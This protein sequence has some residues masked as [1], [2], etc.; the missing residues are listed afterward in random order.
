M[1][2]FAMAAASAFAQEFRPQIPKAWD[3]EQLHSMQL[4]LVGIGVPPKEAP[5]EYYYR[6]PAAT[7]YRSYP[8]YLPGKEPPG[9]NEWL[10]QQE[11]EVVFDAAKLKSEADWIRVGEAIFTMPALIRG[12]ALPLPADAAFYTRNG[13]PVAPNGE[14]PFFR[15]VV[16][17]K[18]EPL[19]S[20][21]R[22]ST[23]HVRVLPDGSIVMGAQG[24]SPFV[25]S[26]RPLRRAISPP[27][28][29]P[30]ARQLF[31]RW[32]SVQWLKPDPAASILATTAE[33]FADA[34]ETE[35]AG[36]VARPGTSLFAPPKTPDLIGIQDRKYLDATG[37]TRHR[38]IGDLMRHAS[39]AAG[40]H[41]LSEAGGVLHFGE[42]PEPPRG[43]RLSDEQ[44]YA[45]SKYLYSLKPPPNPHQA[46]ELARRGE[47]IFKREGC[48]ECHTPPLYTNNQ[49]TPAAGFNVPPEHKQKF[50]VMPVSVA[51]DPRL[52]ME[53]RKATGYYRVPSLKGVWYRG[54]FEHNGSVATLE[55]W[56]D[57]SRLRDD[58]VPTGFKGHK[59]KTR[60]VRGHEFGLKLSGGEKKALIAFLKTL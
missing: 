8:F 37:I 50:D 39:L 19:V 1:L 17:K 34:R 10:K 25:S 22:C 15:Y 54:P 55:D 53:S 18:G 21:T 47:G 27:D 57:P 48:A 40:I 43:G 56:F 36:V 60:A 3:D 28:R 23:C 46:S 32:Y 2:M 24:N 13:V 9:Y 49:L 35:V 26:A 31:F 59:V 12:Q 38:S 41:F 45:V 7:V 11:P 30:A 14:I 58:Y 6:I 29:L 33:E 44:L 52:A 5:A 51:T 42:R 20:V 16:V 4:P